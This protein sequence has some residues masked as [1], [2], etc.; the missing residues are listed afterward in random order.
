MNSPGLPIPQNSPEEVRNITSLEL[1]TLPTTTYFSAFNS[2][3]E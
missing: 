2:C 1:Q 3:I